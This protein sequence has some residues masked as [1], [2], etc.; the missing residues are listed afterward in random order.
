MVSKKRK[1]K[2]EELQLSHEKEIA[3]MRAELSGIKSAILAKPIPNATYS[4]NETETRYASPHTQPQHYN[5]QRF[6]RRKRCR[7][8]EY[9]NLSRCVHCFL[10]GSCDY[11]MFAEAHKSH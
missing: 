6:T 11:M 8:C 7:K 4:R 9:E 5:Q 3:A 2:P 1:K 10:C